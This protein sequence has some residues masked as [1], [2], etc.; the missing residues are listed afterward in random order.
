MADLKKLSRASRKI[1]TADDLDMITRAAAAGTNVRVDPRAMEVTAPQIEVRGFL[2]EARGAAA[3]GQG[4]EVVGDSTMRLAEEHGKLVAL[5]QGYEADD[6]LGMIETDLATAISR[7]PDE[8][9]WGEI[10]NAHLE[11]AKTEVL[12]KPRLGIA[13]QQVAAAHSRWAQQ[14]R[15]NVMVQQARRTLDKGRE[16]IAGKYTR[17]VGEKDFQAARNLADDPQVREVMGEDW[18]ATATVKANEAEQVSAARDRRD[19]IEQDAAATPDMWLERNPEPGDMDPDDWQAGQAMARRVISARVSDA[20]DEIGDG[21]ATGKIKTAQDIEATAAG[22]L[23]PAALERA[24][25]DLRKMQSDA[26]RAENLSEKGVTKNFGLLLSEVDKYDKAADADG[27]KYARLVWQIKTL[28]PE[29]LRGEI[30]QP[31][32]RKWNPASGPD[33]PE[34]LRGFVRDT[35]RNW[36]E[37]GKFGQTRKLRPLAPGDAGY[38]DGTEAMKWVDDPPARDAAAARRGEAEMEMAKWLKENPTATIK[39]AKEH[40]LRSSSASLLPSDV[41]SLL[42]RPAPAA[43]VEDVGARLKQINA[44]VKPAEYVDPGTGNADLQFPTG[45]G[46]IDPSLLPAIPFNE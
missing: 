37:D 33:A 2:D 40:L 32:A 31:L 30:T 35:L 7:E 36:F 28:M 41:S 29:E 10:L 5:N 44:R 15:H 23:G 9:K 24:K 38:Y 42:R 34:P 27:S 25:E 14:Q 26:W 46:E 6:E 13:Q 21:I 45:P 16:N 19:A 18:A 22:R 43:P 11:K 17:L 20:A 4:L 1:P 3:I 12:S 39:E 8:L